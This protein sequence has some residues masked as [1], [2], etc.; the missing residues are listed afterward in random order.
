LNTELT[1]NLYGEAI[2]EHYMA[3]TSHITKMS[4]VE[5]QPAAVKRRPN[6]P[7]PVPDLGG[8]STEIAHDDNHPSGAVVHGGGKQLLRFILFVAYFWTCCCTY[9]IFF[10]SYR[11]AAA[12]DG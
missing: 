1:T 12:N 3:D 6:M 9:V 7:R 4:A 10:L 8:G 11:I 2:H 5:A